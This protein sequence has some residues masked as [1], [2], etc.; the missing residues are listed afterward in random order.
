MESIGLFASFTHVARWIVRDV[1]LVG[2][3][4]EIE[5]ARNDLGESVDRRQRDIVEE[6]GVRMAGPLS[7]RQ[8]LRTGIDRALLRLSANDP[9][10]AALG[11]VGQHS[12][13]VVDCSFSTDEGLTIFRRQGNAAIDTRLKIEL[14]PSSN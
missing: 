4:I 3:I 10:I 12:R 1:D 13:A 7:A 2:G 9:K 6:H 14:R 11:P 5:G 8:E